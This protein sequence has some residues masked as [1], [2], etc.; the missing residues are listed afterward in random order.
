VL[1]AVRG[2][3]EKAPQVAAIL[4]TDGAINRLSYALLSGK[5]Q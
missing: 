2:A 5:I 4:D 1:P 3:D